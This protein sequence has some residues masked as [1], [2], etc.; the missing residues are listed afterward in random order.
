MTTTRRTLL[1]GSL[2]RGGVQGRRVFG[3]LIPERFGHP[4]TVG[5]RR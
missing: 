2:I 3:A 4:Q 1:A 5:H